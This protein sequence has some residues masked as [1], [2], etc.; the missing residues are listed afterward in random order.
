MFNNNLRNCFFFSFIL[1]QFVLFSSL[2]SSYPDDETD[3]RKT[4][5]L[6]PLTLFSSTPEDIKH[7][8]KAQTASKDEKHSDPLKIGV[9]KA[10]IVLSV[11]LPLE[12]IQTRMQ[13]LNAKISYIDMAKIVYKNQNIKGLYAGIVPKF[14]SSMIRNVCRWYMIDSL[15][16]FYKDSISQQLDI[17]YPQLKLILTGASVA[18]FDTL[19]LTPFERWKVMLMTRETK[20]SL[21]FNSSSSIFKELFRGSTTVYPQSFFNWTSVLLADQQLKYY[22]KEHT[23]NKE[24]PIHWLLGT[25]I[26]LGFVSSCLLLPIQVVKTQFQ[27]DNPVENKGIIKTMKSIVKSQGYK[28]LYVGWRMDA[29]RSVI[30]SV[31]DFYFLGLLNSKKLENFS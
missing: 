18:A 11:D 5:T 10:A 30:F 27:K 13:A 1:V 6:R 8:T 29:A 19:A 9:L 12:G 2:V 7:Y 20:N 14:S 23:L 21:F 22:A 17:N 24:V 25:S 16:G 4:S 15:P 28:G 26:T 3:D 31:F